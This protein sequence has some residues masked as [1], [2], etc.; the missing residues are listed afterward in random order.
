M[1]HAKDIKFL[2]SNGGA[3]SPIT[4]L[5]ISWSIASS[6]NLTRKQRFF[7]T[8]AG[9]VPDIDGA[10]IVLDLLDRSATDQLR[11]WSEYHHVLGHNLA[12]CAI[13]TLFAVVFARRRWATA[14]LVLTTFHLH[15]IG[16]LIGAR[17][18]DGYQW[19]INYLFPFS[20]AL[21][22]TWSGQ[23]YLNAWPNVVI[24]AILLLLVFHSTWK[25]G[26]SPLELVSVKAN[27]AL[28]N[29]LRLRFGT[30]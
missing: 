5:L 28:V 21:Q 3:M 8:M 6:V 26:I 11:W 23:W 2:K 13:L 14:A 10:G 12:L 9:I 29:T 1:D 15:L 24:T 7:A 19:P 20:D 22:L 30:P 16:D 27:H 17:G 18:P 4:H 25:K